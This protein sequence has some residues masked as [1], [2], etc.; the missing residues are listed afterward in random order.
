MSRPPNRWTEAELAR[1]AS[2]AADRF[3]EE[4]LRDVAYAGHFADAQARFSKLLTALDDL[5]AG[6]I[7]ENALRTVLG[8]E[9]LA[10]A[11]RYLAGPPISQDDLLVL[12]RVRSLAQPAKPSE[13]DATG[14]VREV[15][16]RLIDPFRFPWVAERR[17]PRPDERGAA[18][19]ASATLLAAQKLETA[20]RNEGKDRQ[21]ARVKDYLRTLGFD[22]TPAR[23]I[24]TLVGGPGQRQFC[25]EC[26]LGERKADI[27]VR[28]ADTRLLA[29]E[30]KV[31]N[32]ATN[33][34]KRL[35]NDAAAKAE[36]WVKT[37]GTMQVVPA[38]MLAGVYKL[39][40]L[41]QSQEHGLALF[42]SH[43]LAQ[44]GAFIEAARA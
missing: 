7:D 36:Y 44:L 18:L 5:A 2:H 15:L 26:L 21:E 42:W 31:S 33:S 19:L 11:M 39:R 4:R 27:V 30:C 6:A 28:L 8:D 24:T 34:I 43:D 37:F 40:N 16:G 3:R 1:E 14:K 38:A 25:G 35:N 41:L 29:I 13:P 10:E 12:A 20:R 9:A 23:P 32:S 17:A 22:E